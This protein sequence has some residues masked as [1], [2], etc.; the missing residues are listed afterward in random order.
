MKTIAA[1]AILLTLSSLLPSHAA[2]I[3]RTY[4]YFSIGGVTLD[5]IESE[6]RRRG[7]KMTSTGSSHPGLTRMQFTTN[8]TYSGEGRR[9]SVTAAAVTVKADVILP[10]WRRPRAADRDTRFIWETLSSDIKRHEDTHVRIAR[11]HAFDLERELKQIRNHFGCEAAKARVEAK[12][13]E[14]LEKH[15]REQA[16]FDRVEGAT[17]EKRLVRLMESRLD[18]IEQGR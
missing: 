14:I 10:R 13:A 8:V 5:E 16:A 7:P 12:T 3:D 11:N 15:D 1:T 4:S 2:T 17:F 6:L 9:C 18:R